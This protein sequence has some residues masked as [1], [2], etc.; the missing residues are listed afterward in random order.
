MPQPST[1][2]VNAKVKVNHLKKGMIIK[3]Y[4]RFSSRY[5]NMDEQTSTFVRHNFRG[6]RA[7]VLRDRKKLNLAIKSVRPGD[8]L[9][10]IF[11]FPD[12]LRRP[13]VSMRMLA[14][15]SQQW[16]ASGP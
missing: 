1:E 5:Q 3:A 15:N 13:A 7:I 11:S 2:F 4:S 9:R 8:T 6:T 14:G 12:N 16:N 10:G